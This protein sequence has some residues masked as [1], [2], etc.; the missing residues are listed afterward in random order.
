MSTLFMQEFAV[1]DADNQDI[2]YLMKRLAVESAASPFLVNLFK[3]IVPKSVDLIKS[4]IP[5][6]T[7]YQDGKGL[8]KFDGGQ[9]SN[10]LKSIQHLNFLAYEDVLVDVP[11]GFHGRLIPY[12]ELMKVQSKV[13]L[14]HGQNVISDYITEVSMFLSNADIR[15]SLKSHASYYAGV[16]KER[17]AYQ[18]DVEKFFNKKNMTLA[19]CKLGTVI[20]RFADLQK[21]FELEKELHAIRKSQDFAAVAANIQ[22]VADILGLVKA[23]L[24]AGDIPEMSQQVARNLSE[25]AFEVAKYAEYM[26]MYG[27]FLE[28]SLSCV[29]GIADKFEQLTK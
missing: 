4:F 28:S 10:V 12:L 7:K 29:K 8:V 20:E 23:R 14:T 16:R 26:S 17:M 3:N 11:E 21:I 22:R 27:Y 5:G 24:D 19:K 18:A 25:G 15:N 9:R 6:L 13:V 2:E 1:E